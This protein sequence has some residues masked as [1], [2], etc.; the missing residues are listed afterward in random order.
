MFM[1]LEEIPEQ[2]YT[3]IS[4]LPPNTALK[5]LPLDFKTNYRR[6][7]L[8]QFLNDMECLTTKKKKILLDSKGMETRS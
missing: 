2:T 5:L 7:C 1:A 4:F 6:K 3:K 8:R